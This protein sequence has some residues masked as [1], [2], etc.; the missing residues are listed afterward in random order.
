MPLVVTR[1]PARR[2]RFDGWIAGFG[3]ASG[4][5]IV[6][7]HWPV[8]PFGPVSD[9]MLESAAG[10]RLLIAATA[11]LADFVA[12]TYTF[13]E[14]T[15][16][17][18]DVRREPER[19]SLRAGPLQAGFAL[20]RRGALGMALRSVP[21]GLAGRPAW[22]AACDAPARLL[23]PGVRTRGSAGNGRREWYGARDLRPIESA[24]ARLAGEDL[25]ALAPVTPP[26]RFG[27]GS[28]PARPAVVR[29]TTTVEV[30]PR[31]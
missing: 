25:G 30:P 1:T 8:S 16:A 29:L 17:P 15:V 4:T 23:L 7:G 26:V 9:V 6:L 11:E 19:W 3:T 24:Q 14:V 28:V 13:D 10:H 27:F 20:G 22:V 5:R 21:R 31:G 12:A 18:V 2:L